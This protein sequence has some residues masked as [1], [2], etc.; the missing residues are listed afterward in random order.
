MAT[1]RLWKALGASYPVFEVTT[2]AHGTFTDDR[3]ISLV[4]ERGAGPVGLAPGTAEVVV[5]GVVPSQPATADQNA[6]V[7]LTTYGAVLLEQLTG[8]A[9]DFLADRWFGRISGQRVDDQGD[10]PSGQARTTTTL[11]CADW[12]NTVTQIDPDFYVQPDNPALLPLYQRAFTAANVPT[13]GTLSGL[14]SS[15]DVVYFE[16]PPA[17]FDVTAADAFGKYAADLGVLIRTRR[18]GHPQAIAVDHR[19]YEGAHWADVAPAPL[20]RHQVVRPVA[21]EQ[22]ATN[23][24]RIVH[25]YR[26]PANPSAVV[27]RTV[28]LGSPSVVLH[29]EELDLSHVIASTTHLDAANARLYRN[30]SSRYAVRTVKLDLLALLTRNDPGD[31]ALVGQTLTREQGDVIALAYDWPPE[32]H[33]VYFIDRIRESVT[34]TSWVVELDLSPHNHVTGLPSPPVPGPTWDSHYPRL[35]TWEGTNPDRWEDV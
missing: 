15:W 33:G 18:S 23:T 26:S 14:G 24:S 10:G 4:T 11:T 8:Y 20:L 3:L 29:T 32:V 28:T 17:A 16:P 6:R 21:W 1:S 9:R 31:R 2:D 34:N 13:V 25:K 12:A 19:Q 27:T 22:A 5:R 7:R 35:T 30:A